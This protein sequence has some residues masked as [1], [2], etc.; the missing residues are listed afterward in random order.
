MF[1]VNV[2]GQYDILVSQKL[3]DKIIEAKCTGVELYPLNDYL[4]I[5]K[6]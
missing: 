2:Y 3:R 1:N 5:D 6:D 4:T